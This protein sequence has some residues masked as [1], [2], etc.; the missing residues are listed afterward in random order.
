MKISYNWIKEYVKLKA[1]SEELAKGLTMSGSEVEGI[2]SR[3]GDQIMGLEITSNRPDCLNMVGMAREASAVFDVDLRL[4]DMG[5]APA[6]AA[7]GGPEVECVIKNTDLCPKYTARIIS[8]VNVSPG[9]GKISERI[10]SLGVRPVNNIVDITNFCLM[11]SGQPLHAFD[12]DK[13]K[14]EKII[15]RE[16]TDGEKI[17]TIDGIERKLNKGMLVI[18]DES[19]PIAIA[20]I[21]GGK[22]TEVTETTRNILLESAY[23]E[24]ISIRRTG[25]VL[26]LSSDSSYRFERG[27]DRGM[28]NAASDRATAL[29]VSEAGGT[30]HDFYEEGNLTAE[31]VSIDLD[32]DR[33][34]NTLGILLGKDQVMHILQRLGMEVEDEGMSKIKVIVPTFREDLQKE[35]DLVE[36][37]ARIYGYDKIPTTVA[38]IVPQIVRKE[39]SRRVIEKLHEVLPSAGLNEIMTYSLI[40]EA[41]VQ[42]HA[43]ITKDPVELANPLS[44][45]QKILTPQLLDGMLKSI[46]W[47][48]NR[49][50]KDLGLFEIGKIY[51]KGSGKE[52]FIE[53]PALCVALSGVLRKNWSEDAREAHL[54]D[55][56]GV[57]ELVFRKM[58]ISAGFKKTN[59]EGLKAAT[60]VRLDGEKES[61]G[62]MGA[63]DKP[64]LNQYNIEQPVFIAQIKLDKVIEKAT[65]ATRYR[66]IPR[67]PF[68][69]RDISILCDEALASSEIY[70]I[71]SSSAEEI[72]RGVELVDTYEGKQIEAGKKSLTYSVKYGL[73]T[74]TLTDEEIDPVHSKIKDTLQKKLGVS[75]R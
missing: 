64:L 66:A 28:I 24:P 3:E 18:A 14:G 71:L 72:I 45:D 23:F 36:E 1:N 9:E 6:V 35:I 34:G 59:I 40:S 61:I 63:V 21:M 29:I 58:S 52:K 54:Y 62:F 48:I 60:E 33:A 44:E 46:S 43:A 69:S 37:I 5:I 42:R 39:Y 8:G 31:K 30:I 51:S 11:E 12:L 32:V 16:A 13:I 65:L 56:K 73:D 50:N 4:P 27:V 55:L 68:S 49:N 75:F 67:F 15:I 57:I 41:A 70:N 20:G 10:Q 47:N 38:R 19:D 25:R 17:T 7:P 22:N 53:T 74:R 26:A 2:E